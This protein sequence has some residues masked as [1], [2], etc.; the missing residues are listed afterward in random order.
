M[1]FKEFANVGVFPICL[2]TKYPE[3]I[4]ETVKLSRL[5]LAAF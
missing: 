2:A 4:V 1:L 3:K 5:D